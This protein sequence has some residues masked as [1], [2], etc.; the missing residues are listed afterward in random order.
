M[1]NALVQE[2]AFKGI[3]VPGGTKVKVSAYADDK[4]LFCD[5]EYELDV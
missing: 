4:V 3:S 1:L 5:N 2:P